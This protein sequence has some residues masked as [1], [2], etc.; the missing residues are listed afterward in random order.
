M[1]A[2]FIL[3]AAGLCCGR[4]ST[5]EAKSAKEVVEEFW[6]LEIQGTRLTNEGWRKADIFFLHPSAPP[7]KKTISIVSG[8]DPCSA[9]E[10]WVKG[11]R[12]EIAN[13]CFGLGRIDDQLR[14]TASDSAYDKIAVVYHLVLT[15]KSWE[16]E[17]DGI[18]EKQ[19]SGP[20]T[21]RIE[22]PEPILWLS[23]DTAVRYVT[24]MRDKT[25]DPIIKRNANETLS[26]LMK[27]H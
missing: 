27:L 25:T 17:P 22:N 8:K 5:K 26:K 21:W 24:K 6:K 20:A 1:I 11:N 9:G 13:G 16:L 14:Y 19:V 10:R 3:T 23:V 7:Q 2:T 4:P 18:T 15:D 12:A